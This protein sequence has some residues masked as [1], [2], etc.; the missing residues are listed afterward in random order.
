MCVEARDVN[1]HSTMHRTAPKSKNYLLPTINRAEIK[2]P[3]EREWVWGTARRGQN[4]GGENFK[5]S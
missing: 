3:W 4:K 2:K 5:F 1:G